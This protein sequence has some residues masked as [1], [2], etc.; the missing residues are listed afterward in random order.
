[1]LMKNNYFQRFKDKY[2]IRNHFPY[3]MNYELRFKDNLIGNLILIASFLL[4]TVYLFTYSE[5]RFDGMLISIIASGTLSAILIVFL[6]LT[7]LKHLRLHLLETIFLFASSFSFSSLV[8]IECYREF[9]DLENPLSI[10]GVILSALMAL[11]IFILIMN[12]KLSK[13]ANLESKVNEDGSTSY[14]R[15]KY[16]VLAYSEWIV[17]LTYFINLI[18]VFFLVL[19][20]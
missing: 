18:S 5:L 2:D 11:I 14:I 3:E 8:C 17:I 4:G 15:P 6:F 20:K 1:M 9:K 19:V 13:W 12:P 16:F 7:P 10:A